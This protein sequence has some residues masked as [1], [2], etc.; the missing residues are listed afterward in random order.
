M[1]QYCHVTSCLHISQHVPI[2]IC[3]P[4]T[5]TYRQ[6]DVYATLRYIL[7]HPCPQTVIAACT[8]DCCVTLPNSMIARFQRWKVP[9]KLEGKVIHH[10]PGSLSRQNFMRSNNS[11]LDL[12]NSWPFAPATALVSHPHAQACHQHV[13]QCCRTRYRN[14]LASSRFLVELVLSVCSSHLHLYI[15]HAEHDLCTAEATGGLAG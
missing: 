4:A 7:D 8:C 10:N 3:M 13:L 2:H 6:A 9:V 15:H 14:L 12:A 1:A 5:T 11:C